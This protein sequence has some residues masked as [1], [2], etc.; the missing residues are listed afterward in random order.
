MT[1]DVIS[2]EKLQGCV[3]H[4]RRVA[5]A[6]RRSK[7]LGDRLAFDDVCFQQVGIG[8]CETICGMKATDFYW[9]HMSNSASYAK[10][11]S[12]LAASLGIALNVAV[13][14]S[15]RNRLLY[16]LVAYAFRDILIITIK[17]SYS[18]VGSRDVTILDART[19]YAGRHLPAI[20][21]YH[22]FSDLEGSTV[23]NFMKGENLLA[24]SLQRRQEGN[25][26]RLKAESRA[27]Y[28]GRPR[29]RRYRSYGIL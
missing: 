1:T 27:W 4:V 25:L 17:D 12:R 14:N 29:N 3:A 26:E 9:A 23:Q 2:M 6:L 5:A 8:V 21:I 24:D 16:Q 22:F 7:E 15:M 28:K 19:D 10:G 18:V 11:N 20:G 13:Q